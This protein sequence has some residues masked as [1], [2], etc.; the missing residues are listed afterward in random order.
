[1]NTEK[2]I[3]FLEWL[4]IIG[5]MLL[6]ADSIA[7]ASGDDIRQS[8]DNNILE[9]SI[10]VNPTLTSNP[11]LNAGDNV[12]GDIDIQ[13]DKNRAYAFGMGDV[14]INDCYRS[15]QVLIFQGSQLNY[16]CMAD[17][18]DAK[19]LHEAAAKTRCKLDGYRNLFG[20]E[21]ACI[22]MNTMAVIV[23]PPTDP[24][25]ADKDDEDYHEKHEAEA[26]QIVAQIGAL[27]AT[28]S[29]LE[30][31]NAELEAQVHKAK[32]IAQKAYDDPVATDLQQRLDAFE[33]RRQAA[34]DALEGKE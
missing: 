33:E 11:T 17:S 25:T 5:V 32:K 21:D 6:L 29:A 27:T 22:K 16:W 30:D 34:R 19:G 4:I 18:L 3:S 14:D 20:D 31:D 1:M 15:F 26:Q 12:G 7:Q 8:N 2:R 10:E 9:G 13:G 23:L 24:P 28:V